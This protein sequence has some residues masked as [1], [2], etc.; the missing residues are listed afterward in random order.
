MHH[1][2]I[3][4]AN[5]PVIY[6]NKVLKALKYPHSINWRKIAP[7]KIIPFACINNENE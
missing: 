6:T 1:T 3:L 2:K 7:A 4:L 5:T